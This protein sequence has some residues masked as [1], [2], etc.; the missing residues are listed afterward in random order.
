M[1]PHFVPNANTKSE[2]NNSNPVNHNNA[3]NKPNI[4]R[5]PISDKPIKN[6]I[7]YT[8]S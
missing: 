5:P 2:Q 1:K 7:K 3:H 8:E 6:P 4:P